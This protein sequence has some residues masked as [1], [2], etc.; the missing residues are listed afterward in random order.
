[1]MQPGEM[2]RTFVEQGLVDITE[3]QLLIR[4]DYQSFDDYW[5][6]MWRGAQPT[7]LDQET[8]DRPRSVAAAGPA[9][10]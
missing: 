4:M 10:S 7:P 6:P 1:M 2:K 8:K 5:A 9:A 3:M